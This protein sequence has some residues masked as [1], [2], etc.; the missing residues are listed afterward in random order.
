MEKASGG[1]RRNFPMDTG[2]FR[3]W[4]WGSKTKD[5]GLKIEDKRSRIK[6]WG[7]VIENW[8]LIIDV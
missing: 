6:E 1:A 2:H 3:D 7:F 8:W 4:D 5:G